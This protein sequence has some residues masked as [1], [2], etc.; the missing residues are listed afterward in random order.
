MLITKMM[1]VAR[2]AQEKDSVP[3][4]DAYLRIFHPVVVERMME[5][6]RAVVLFFDTKAHGQ[7]PEDAEERML[8]ALSY[9][10]M[11]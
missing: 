6:I 10:E 3:W 1:E 7:E 5:V 2:A 4:G 11:L 8:T 9:L